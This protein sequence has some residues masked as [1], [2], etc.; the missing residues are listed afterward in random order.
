MLSSLEKAGTVGGDEGSGT[1]VYGSMMVGA[2]AETAADGGGIGLSEMVL[3]ALT[4]D[5]E[6]P[7]TPTTSKR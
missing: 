1:A 6:Q 7:K 2:L 5:A 3:R 4:P